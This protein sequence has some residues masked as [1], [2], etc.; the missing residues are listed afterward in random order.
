LPE[1][2]RRRE[3]RLAKIRQAKA[4]LEKEAA[5]AA[6]GWAESAARECGDDEDTATGAGVGAASRATPKP[7]AQRDFTDPDSKIMLTGDGAFHQCYN[8]QAVV[9]E[10]HQVIVAT[11]VN[12]NAADVGNLIAM[13]EQTA[14]NTG[15]SPGQLL[16]D[17]GYCPADNLERA[18]KFTA[19][20]GTEFYVATGRVR[21]DEPPPVAPRG[22]IPKSATGKQRMARKLSTRKGRAIYARRKA[23]VEP[24]FGQMSTL[25]NAK[26]LLL[27]GLDQARGEWL[28]LATCHNLRKLHGVVGVSGPAALART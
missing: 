9:D 7:K 22:P 19:Q 23:I 24:V 12:T 18:S 14:A 20:H 25:Q 3:T 26:Q 6:R 2:L 21:R 28:L 27:G 5:A 15:Q 13:T 17:A 8:A 16:A 1:E 4:A 10:D 11:D